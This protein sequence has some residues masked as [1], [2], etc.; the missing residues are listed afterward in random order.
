[1]MS[2]MLMQTWSS[3]L[4]Q[5]ILIV[6]NLTQISIVAV[7]SVWG[8]INILLKLFK[9]NTL[10]RLKKNGLTPRNYL[11]TEL[12]FPLLTYTVFFSMYSYRQTLINVLFGQYM[13]L[14]LLVYVLELWHIGFVN[15]IEKTRLSKYLNASFTNFMGYILTSLVFG[16]HRIIILYY[17]YVFSVTKK[18]IQPTNELL[19]QIGFKVESVC[20]L[21]YAPLII[22][23]FINI[24]LQNKYGT[25]YICPRKYRTLK[26]NFEKELVDTFDLNKIPKEE[27]PTCNI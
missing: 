16:S 13:Y 2:V 6:I 23:S 15:F 21:Y 7:S 27:W 1:M 20:L 24:V 4:F 17:T 18:D 12:I 9:G 22:L 25:R 26:Y 3:S 11:R 5:S 14:I 19:D 8:L 10:I